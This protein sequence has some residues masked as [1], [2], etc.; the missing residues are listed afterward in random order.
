MRGRSPD[1][2]AVVHTVLSYKN[3]RGWSNC[4]GAY[5]GVLVEGSLLNRQFLFFWDQPGANAVAV[6]SLQ[7]RKRRFGSSKYDAEAVR[8][9]QAM[10]YSLDKGS[11]A[12]HPRLKLPL[13]EGCA[14]GTVADGETVDLMASDRAALVALWHR[15]PLSLGVKIPSGCA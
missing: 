9:V 7:N 4:V 13:C 15:W 14:P 8:F 10:L 6:S 2:S 3:F 11:D 12:A 5:Q 1:S